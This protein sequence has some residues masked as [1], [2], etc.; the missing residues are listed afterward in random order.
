MHDDDVRTIVADPEVFV[1]SDGSAID[2]TSPAGSLPVHPRDYGTFPRVLARYVREEGVLS[3]EAAIRKMTSLP[4][5]RFG[6]AGRGRIAEG[7]FADLVA[8]DAIVIADGSTYRDPHR[9]P[10]G[11]GTVVVNGTVAFEDSRLARAGRVLHR[12]TRR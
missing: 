6:L 2:P 1:A 3:L 11:I 10:S 7:S 9:F 12:G 4:A 8:F 5:D